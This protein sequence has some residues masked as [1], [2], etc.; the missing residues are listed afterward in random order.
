MATGICGV[1]MAIMVIDK[2]LNSFD[3]TKK[4]QESEK[5]NP[6]SVNLSNHPKI[7]IASPGYRYF[8]G[9]LARAMAMVPVRTISLMPIGLSI[10]IHASIFE[11]AP[12][13]SMA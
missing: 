11:A 12:V 8:D 4:G 3:Y 7:S 1:S 6:A 9:L 13:T 2:L 10:S 5:L